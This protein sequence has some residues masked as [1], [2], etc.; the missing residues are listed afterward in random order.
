MIKWIVCSF[1]LLLLRIWLS[2]WI[3]GFGTMKWQYDVFLI[4]YGFLMF[5]LLCVT[6]WNR[7]S[8]TT[9]YS[10]RKIVYLFFF[11]IR[12]FERCEDS[13][14]RIQL[15]CVHEYAAYNATCDQFEQM[16]EICSDFILCITKR[17]LAVEISQP[18]ILIL[19]SFL[20]LWFLPRQ[21]WSF[22]GSIR[23]HLFH[24]VIY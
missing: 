2:T 4:L 14:E 16:I 3:F 6:K 1:S 10:W 15:Q 11:L 23:V 13:W 17:D 19:G 21:W 22:L 20:Y 8:A 18:T 24:I 12:T 7:W 5:T 9:W